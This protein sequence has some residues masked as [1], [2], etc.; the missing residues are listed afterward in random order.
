MSSD[1]NAL[2]FLAP[3][4]FSVIFHPSPHRALGDIIDIGFILGKICMVLSLLDITGSINM[5][6]C[7]F[8]DM[9]VTVTLLIGT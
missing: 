5:A 9:V 4:C 6:I 8:S 1:D 7:N 3:F 2:F